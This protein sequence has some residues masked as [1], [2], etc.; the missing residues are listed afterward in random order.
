MTINELLNKAA[1]DKKNDLDS[2]IEV[3]NGIFYNHFQ[4]Y[5]ELI[6]KLNLFERKHAMSKLFKMFKIE[7][8][9]TAKLLSAVENECLTDDDWIKI[10]Q[11]VAQRL[12]EKY[13]KEQ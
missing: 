6:R 13:N 3:I 1:N 2:N 12:N 8:I 4:E 5:S 10:E 7:D 9:E 11:S